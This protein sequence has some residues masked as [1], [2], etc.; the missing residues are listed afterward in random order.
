MTKKAADYRTTPKKNKKNPKLNLG[1]PTET[2]LANLT[3]DLINDS[4]NI[5]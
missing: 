1:L 2:N 5:L 4:I 3:T